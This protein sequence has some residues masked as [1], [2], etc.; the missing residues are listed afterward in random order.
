MVDNGASSSGVAAEKGSGTT[1]LMGTSTL[2][3]GATLYLDGGRSIQNDGT[4]IADGGTVLLGAEP[5]GTAAG[6]G[7]VINV[8]TLDIQ[9][10][11][12]SFAGVLG[13]AT[14]T[15]YGELEKSAGTGTSTVTANFVNLGTVAVNSGTLAFDASVAGGTFDIASNTALDLGGIATSGTMSF[16]GSSAVLQIADAADFA[17]SIGTIGGGNQI[18]LSNFAWDSSATAS[19]AASTGGGGTLTV[20]ASA[21]TV[22]LGFSTDL[23]SYSYTVASDGHSGLLIS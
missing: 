7:H 18:D 21:G 19:F 13:N 12:T 4:F 8:G 14:L 9:T 5:S 3:A 6:D 16:I 23:S 10:D 2:A 20:I 17:A 15:N 22:H 11:G 1:M